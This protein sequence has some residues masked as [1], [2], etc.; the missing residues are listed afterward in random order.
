MNKKYGI[1]RVAMAI[2]VGC[3][4]IGEINAS[5]GSLLAPPPPAVKT[6]RYDK[7]KEF[8]TTG[9]SSSLMEVD[10]NAVQLIQDPAQSWQKQIN[11]NDYIIFLEG[12]V[13]GLQEERSDLQEQLM[14]AM[15]LIDAL[16]RTIHNETRPAPSPILSINEMKAEVWPSLIYL[17]PAEIEEEQAVE[18]A[19][20]H[21]GSADFE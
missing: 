7:I 15:G 8:L 14:L 5:E 9:K 16:T 3:I 12:R 1:T 18:M 21:V 2:M 10:G 11:V 4:S 17:D 13:K 20:R 6:S 19:V